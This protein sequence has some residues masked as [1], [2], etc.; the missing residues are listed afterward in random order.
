MKG[1]NREHRTYYGCHG[2]RDSANR[3]QIPDHPGAVYVRED[4]LL[5]AV[6]TVIAERVFG[7]DRRQHLAAQ[8]DTAPAQAAQQHAQAINAA[9]AALA[10]ITTR[11]D[12]IAAE[13]EET[14]AADR[15]WR[16]RLRDRFNTLET[17]RV[18]A[19]AHLAHLVATQPAAATDN[20][21]LLDAMPHLRVALAE[22]PTNLQRNLY[23]VLNLEITLI[24]PRQAHIKITLVADTATRINAALATTPNRDPSRTVN[25]AASPSAI[26]QPT[27]PRRG[28]RGG[29]PSR[30]PAVL[31]KL[32]SCIGCRSWSLTVAMAAVECH[33]LFRVA[34]GSPCQTTGTEATPKR[35]L[36]A[37]YRVRS[38]AG[39]RHRTG[40]VV[41]TGSSTSPR[42]RNVGR[43]RSSSTGAA[44]ARSGTRRSSVPMAMPT[45]RRAS[46]APR[47]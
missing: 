12:N 7:T 18:E 14:P 41:R 20:P 30:G 5:P 35:F 15:A 27:Q 36:Y 34:L 19:A 29:S 17:Q 31:A 28:G 23:E 42:A 21:A 33:D 24:N 13:L 16:T 1:T 39:G 11:Q 3:P 26:H 40:G 47:Q 22:L 4:V 38:G 9:Q 32:S 46:D 37:P 8:H 25:P 2:P 6:H 43:Q 44:S 10:D 45:S